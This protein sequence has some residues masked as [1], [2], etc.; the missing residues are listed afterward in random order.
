MSQTLIVALD[1]IFE[2]GDTTP[3]HSLAALD[4]EHAEEGSSCYACHSLLDPMRPIFEGYYGYSNR[5]IAGPKRGDPSTFAF[6]GHVVPTIDDMDDLASA[7][8]SHPRFAL[9]WTQKVCMW[10]NS[11]R[12]NE[13]DPEFIRIA[14]TFRDGYDTDS[15]DDDFRL[16]ILM[17]EL[18]S[19]T[20]VTGA[21]PSLNHDRAEFF[22]SPARSQH[23]C[24]AIRTRVR[25]ACAMRIAEEGLEPGS[26]SSPIPDCVD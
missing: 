16:P 4:E 19:S 8:A 3:P 6:H 17:R 21:T 23:F 18:L 9:A 24:Q 10:A 11:Q 5:G 2:T 14:E 7:M 25:Q 22:V 1:L 15:P 20:L 26:C 13:S 12:C